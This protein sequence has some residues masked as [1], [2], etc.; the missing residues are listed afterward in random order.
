MDNTGRISVAHYLQ[1]N[2][3][4][5]RRKRVILAQLVREL[6]GETS[7]NSR[8]IKEAMGWAIKEHFNI[9]YMSYLQEEQMEECLEFIQNFRYQHFD[10]MYG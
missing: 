4:K 1:L 2:R 6:E 5:E 10:K 8:L 9:P 3:A 7:V